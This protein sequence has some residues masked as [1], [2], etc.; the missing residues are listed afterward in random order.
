MQAMA[1]ENAANQFQPKQQ[2]YTLYN[3]SHMTQDSMPL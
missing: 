2:W 3:L 1:Q